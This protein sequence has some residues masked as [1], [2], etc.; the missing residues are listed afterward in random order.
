VIF[1]IFLFL[2]PLSVVNKGSRFIW[3]RCRSG[4]FLNPDLRFAESG[5]NPDL[6]LVY[7][8]T[9]I[10]NSKIS[11]FFP[12][13]GWSDP[14]T[15]MKI[16]IQSG[17]ETME[18]VILL[19]ESE[20]CKHFRSTGID[21]QLLLSSG[22]AWFIGLSYLPARQHGIS[23]NIYKFGLRIAR[24][25]H[26]RQNYH[27]RGKILKKFKGFKGSILFSKVWTI[28][29]LIHNNSWNLR[30]SLQNRL[31]WPLLSFIQCLRKWKQKVTL[32]FSS[33]ATPLIEKFSRQLNF[34]YTTF[35]YIIY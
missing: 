34:I 33:K 15:Q 3:L 11:E 13:T 30:S 32:S 20:F 29:I 6:D 4:H 8:I 10:R 18:G 35:F 24:I 28:W 19:P 22:T 23:L 12:V 16:Q 25:G 1:N 9:K 21:W 31:Q 2:I 14:M 5:S 27:K 26:R 7:F 17:Y